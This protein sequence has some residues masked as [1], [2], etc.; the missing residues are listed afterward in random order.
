ALFAAA[1]KP[2]GGAVLITLLGGGLLMLVFG[3]LPFL[4]ARFAAEGRFGAFFELSPVRQAFKRAP[5][6]CFFAVLGVYVL[7]L[8]LYLSKVALPP[9][10]AMVLLTPLFIV[11]IYPAKVIT[12][13]AYHRAVA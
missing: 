13:W 3:W 1:K 9:R 12:G 2:E 8:P 6:A 7:A 10:D 4:Q 5:I 11:S